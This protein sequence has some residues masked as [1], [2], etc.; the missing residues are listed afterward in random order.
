MTSYVW[1]KRP[2]DLRTLSK[3]EL[4]L[5]IR[6]QDLL[7]RHL[8]D[9]LYDRR[10]QDVASSAG[11]RAAEVR[12]QA[13]LHLRALPPDPHAAEHRLALDRAVHPRE[14]AP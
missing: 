12:R 13:A 5:L 11:V 2:P 4:I 8:E 10:V 9:A 1:R 3:Q 7:I 6:H 14:E